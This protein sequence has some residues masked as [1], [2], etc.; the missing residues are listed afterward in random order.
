MADETGPVN[1][2]AA[3][4]PE[5]KPPRRAR[6]FVP[7]V[8]VLVSI[9]LLVMVFR[10]E[11]RAH[12]WT[13][14]LIAAESR[15]DR[16]YYAICLAS[17]ADQAVYADVL[18]RIINHPDPGTRR[19]AL[20]ILHFAESDQA[21]KLLAEMITDDDLTLAVQAGVELAKRDREV[22]SHL[23][24]EMLETES[25]DLQRRGIVLLGRT[26]GEQAKQRLRNRLPKLDDPLLIAE[27]IDALTLLDDRIAI[28]TIETYID[29]ERQVEPLPFMQRSAAAAMR[30]L[31]P[32]LRA[33]GVDMEHI[34]ETAT[35]PV[36]VGS[37]AR[38]SL[39]LLTDHGSTNPD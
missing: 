3:A 35:S 10:W 15:E 21:E 38:R 13:N 37:I 36:T 25:P 14:R 18:K 27:T 8:L 7:A 19:Y 23:A 16:D 6:W 24:S 32:Q 30:G 20:H 39:T 34:K 2:S 28:P 26:G 11:I 33:Q 9:W 31:A 17:A 5:G 22:V 4:T 12:W 1:A 29:D